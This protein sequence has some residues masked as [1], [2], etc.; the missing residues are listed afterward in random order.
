MCAVILPITSSRNG[1]RNWDFLLSKTRKICSPQF[2]RMKRIF[3]CPKYMA[4]LLALCI[5]LVLMSCMITRER[6]H[7]TP[8]TPAS[9][10]ASSCLFAISMP[11]GHDAT[12]RHHHNSFWNLSL[13]IYFDL[14]RAEQNHHY[15]RPWVHSIGTTSH[16][17]YANKTW[18]YPNQIVTGSCQWIAQ[19]CPSI[20]RR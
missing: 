20:R 5:V 6:S 9:P 18:I 2:S 1:D 13:Y 17:H 8:V 14:S 4:A 3:T 12:C 11:T 7:D 19:K 15:L 10:A 16:A